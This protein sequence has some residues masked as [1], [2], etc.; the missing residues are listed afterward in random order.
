MGTPLS[1]SMR[2]SNPCWHEYN[3]G[4]VKITNEDRSR[5][6]IIAKGCGH[7]IQRDDPGF[8]VEELSA[9]L[10]RLRTGGVAGE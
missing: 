9:L 5:G 7:F 8:V 1:L 10:D 3:Q 2:Y 6:P 4:L